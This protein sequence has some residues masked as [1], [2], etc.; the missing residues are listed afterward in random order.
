MINIE[1]ENLI[2]KSL[3]NYEKFGI[4]LNFCFDT[5]TKIRKNCSL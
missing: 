3:K 2:S 1:H 5:P 4:C